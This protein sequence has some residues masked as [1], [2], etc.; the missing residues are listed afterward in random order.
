QASC[1]VAG[2]LAAGA[3]PGL[4]ISEAHHWEFSYWYDVNS[5]LD[6]TVETATGK[7]FDTSEHCNVEK[8]LELHPQ[9]SFTR[10]LPPQDRELAIADFFALW[11]QS[12]DATVKTST[13]TTIVDLQADEVLAALAPGARPPTAYDGPFPKAAVGEDAGAVPAAAT[14]DR[15]T[16]KSVE[17]VDMHLA[18]SPEDSSEQA[19][20]EVL[21]PQPPPIKKAKFY[22]VEMTE[23]PAAMKVK[24]QTYLETLM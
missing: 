15:P 21:K 19:G 6:A 11:P 9:L 10:A 23:T 24:G 14:V 12:A 8:V 1:S 13:S 20:P 7:A 16:R 22:K 17:D 18:T 2:L 3:P 5:E 4:D